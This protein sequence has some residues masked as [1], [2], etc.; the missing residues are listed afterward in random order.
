[1]AYEDFLAS[2]QWTNLPP[3]QFGGGLLDAPTNRYQQIMSQIGQTEQ[4]PQGLLDATGG[5]KPEIYNITPAQNQA[6][7]KF[8]SAVEQ[9]LSGGG[10]SSSV[11]AQQAAAQA[12]LAQ[13]TPGEQAAVQAMTVPNLVNL[14]LPF[15]VQLMMNVMGIDAPGT[16]SSGGVSSTSGSPMKGIA[17]KGTVGQVANAVTTTGLAIGN[18]VGGNVG[19]T[20]GTTG[21]GLAGMGSG[22]AGVAA[23]AAATGS[24]MGGLGGGSSSGGGGGGGGSSG[25]S[26]LG[27]MGTGAAGAAA[28]AAA[29]AGG[30]GGGGGGGGCCFIML[31]ARYGDGT[32]DAVVRRYRDEK[33]TDHNKRGYYK[34]AEVFVPLMRQSKLFKFMVAKTF[35][36]PLVSYGKWH[37]GQN[38]HGWIFKPV[39]RF[40][41]KVFNT[42]GSDTKFIRENGETI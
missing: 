16:T 36:D 20:A 13:M 7:M 42:L 37:Y 29:G 3:P 18:A 10:G 15:P 39:E 28:S 24:G 4:V 23:T 14:M 25:G 30:G 32:M 2:Q 26:G 38:K 17:S 19:T 5:Y 12:A 6:I 21:G 22:A 1:M 34:L 31:E 9:R 27:G 8:N 41:M 40:W 35:A 33:I 11:A